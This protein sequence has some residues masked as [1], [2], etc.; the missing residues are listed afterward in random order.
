LELK[1]NRYTGRNGQPSARLD[2]GARD[3]IAWF[4]PG[5]VADNRVGGLDA[6]RGRGAMDARLTREAGW[7]RGRFSVSDGE[8]R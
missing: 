5:D 1:I 2:D 6:A 3:D 7:E 8:K 4:F